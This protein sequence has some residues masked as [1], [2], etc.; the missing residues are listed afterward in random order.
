M[1]DY[2]T[3]LF[4]RDGPIARIT[5]NRPDRLNSFNQQMHHEIAEV[6]RELCSRLPLR[7]RAG[8]GTRSCSRT[9]GATTPLPWLYTVA[10]AFVLSVRRRGTRRSRGGTSTR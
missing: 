5:L 8:K 4:E 3:I 7:L 2:E 9:S 10:R 1:A 6:L